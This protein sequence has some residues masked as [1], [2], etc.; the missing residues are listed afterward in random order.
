MAKIEVSVEMVD[1]CIVCMKKG[2]AAGIDGLTVEHLMYS[3]R[4]LVSTFCSDYARFINEIHAVSINCSINLTVDYFII[5]LINF[6]Q[7]IVAAYLPYN[8]DFFY[9][10]SCN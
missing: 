10:D 3:H 9:A 4:A 6:N 8:F 2:K 7:L 1:K 5:Q